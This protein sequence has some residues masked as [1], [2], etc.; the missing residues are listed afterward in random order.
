MKAKK[1]KSPKGEDLGM[2]GEVEEINLSIIKALDDETHLPNGEGF[3]PVIAPLAI[4]TDGLTLNINADTVAAELAI[5]LKAEKMIILTNQPGILKDVK[6][7]NS[8]IS[9]IT[10]SEIEPLIKKQVIMGGMMPK[11]KACNKATLGGVKKTHIIDGRI[12]HSILLEI[13]TDKGI[14]TEITK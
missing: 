6:D 11:V 9:T 8:L 2:V 5:A 12:P 4:T 3:I 13:F 10:V 7:E 1:F 14:G